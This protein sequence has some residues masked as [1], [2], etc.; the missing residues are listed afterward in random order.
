MPLPQIP[1][2]PLPRGP[3]KTVC[4]HGGST[5]WKLG[6]SSD[7]L[8]LTPVRVLLKPP[9]LS[10]GKGRPS[11]VPRTAEVPA[12]AAERVCGVSEGGR[13]SGD[14][15]GSGRSGGRNAA[16]AGAAVASNGSSEGS[17]GRA[18]SRGGA[19]SYVKEATTTAAVV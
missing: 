15:W 10:F 7:S 12:T 3:C 9:H 8:S 18:G 16:V 2:L 6:P 1:C 14:R 4:R 11:R 19:S 13:C 5:W 17:S